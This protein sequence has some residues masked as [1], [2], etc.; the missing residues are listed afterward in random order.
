M[1]VIISF[2]QVT[3]AASS[4]YPSTTLSLRAPALLPELKYLSSVRLVDDRYH[5]FTFL[6][7]Q[8]LKQLQNILTM[9][10][11]ELAIKQK[12]GKS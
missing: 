5:G 8:G 1:C 12:A 9:C 10:Q 3:Y 4:H 11:G 6:G 2:V 7:H